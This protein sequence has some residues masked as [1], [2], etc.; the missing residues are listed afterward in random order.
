MTERVRLRLAPHLAVTAVMVI[1]YTL[2]TKLGYALTLPTVGSS[3][4]WPP[5]GLAVALVLIFGP[6][7]L[8]AAGVGAVLG[9]LWC[10]KHIDVAA[11]DGLADVL[12]AAVVYLVAGR[13]LDLRRALDTAPRVLRLTAAA[14][15]GGAASATVGMFGLQIQGYLT[16][17]ASVRDAWVVWL[18][19]EVTAMLVIVPVALAID[20]RALTWLREGALEAAG[21]LAV[22]GLLAFLGVRLDHPELLLPGLIWLALRFG[23][24]GA[25]IGNLVVAVLAVVYDVKLFGGQDTTDMLS[26]Q[27]FITVTAVTNLLF[28][29]VT[30]RLRSSEAAREA[31]AESEA[32]L[33]EAQVMGRLGWWMFDAA[34]GQVVAADPVYAMFGLERGAAYEDLMNVVRDEDQERIAAAMST[35]FERAEAFELHFGITPHSGGAEM[36]FVRAEPELAPD[37]T[38]VGLRGVTQDVTE[39]W[40]AERQRHSLEARLHQSQRLETVGQLAGGIAH[41]F[42]NLLAVILNCAEFALEDLPEDNPTRADIDEIRRSAERAATLTRQLLLFSRRELG[43]PEP[44]DLNA[45]VVEAERL[46]RRTIG[47]NIEFSVEL[48]ADLEQITA[49]VG[50]LEQILMNLVVNARDAMPEGGELTVSTAD[51]TV[52]ASDAGPVAPGRYARLSVADTGSGMSACVVEQAFEPFFTTKEQGKGTGLGLAT[53]YGIVQ[54]AGGQIAIDSEEGRGTTVTIDWPVGARQETPTLPGAG[55]TVLVVE[56]DDPVRESALRILADGGYEVISASGAAEALLI[57]EER[58]SIDL[59]LTDIV[60]PD[61]SGQE[62][63][64][65]VGHLP[66]LYMSGYGQRHVEPSTGD[67]LVEKPFSA[68]RLLGAVADALGD[69]A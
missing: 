34:S 60:I 58:T 56:N 30:S 57:C 67:K 47:E 43:H 18:A 35:A 36:L 32:R 8:P 26:V 20:R 9:D 65:R 17:F 1:G 15:A 4:L 33:A 48:D 22:A 50:Q 46:L 62:L 24:P 59:L 21:L 52:E 64:Q 38:V 25:A 63:A 37:G 51:V 66:V 29:T 55:Q 53:V 3:P 10:G 31:L 45:V 28:A 69:A 41:D 12:E 19:G 27:A 44:L 61:M 13:S 2:L 11:I 68:E 14:I 39:V 40:R 42:N 23:L 6:R 54:E 7:Y 16:D 5:S 49:D